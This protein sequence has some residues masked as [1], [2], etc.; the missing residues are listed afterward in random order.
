VAPHLA[1]TF[2]EA[3]VVEMLEDQQAQHAGR[4]GVPVGVVGRGPNRLR[5]VE[6]RERSSVSVHR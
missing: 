5:S 2:V 3:P 6:R 1:L 4:R